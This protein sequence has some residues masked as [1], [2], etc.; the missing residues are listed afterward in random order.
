MVNCI[1]YCSHSELGLT[2]RGVIKAL[3][4]SCHNYH[5]TTVS[6]SDSQFQVN[7]YGILSFRSSF[8][9]SFPQEFDSFF[10]FRPLIAPLWA[11][12]FLGDKGTVL[13]RLSTEDDDLERARNLT[14]QYF[15]GS[16]FRPWDVIIVTWLNVN[17][18]RQFNVLS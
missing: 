18:V 13:Y 9:N 10:D 17:H 4:Q 8:F 15:P 3:H 12:L 11:T 5:I 6:F 2:A 14:Q 16:D 7:E 1:V